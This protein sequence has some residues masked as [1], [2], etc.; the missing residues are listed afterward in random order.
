MLY[1][2]LK[3]WAIVN[4]SVLAPDL[5]L[6]QVREVQMK[7]HN[8]EVDKIDDGIELNMMCSSITEVEP[9]SKSWMFLKPQNTTTTI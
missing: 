3:V 8:D 7:D 5:W 2:F 4:A 6:L 9:V 1:D